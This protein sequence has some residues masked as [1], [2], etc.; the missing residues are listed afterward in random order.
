MVEITSLVGSY[1]SGLLVCNERVRRGNDAIFV[2][3]CQIGGLGCKVGRCGFI[4]CVG[5][6]LYER[7]MI[8]RNYQLFH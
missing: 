5:E 4:D 1:R 2:Q 7:R 3:G 8:K 6:L